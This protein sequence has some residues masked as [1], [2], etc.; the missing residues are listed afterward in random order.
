[1]FIIDAID[2]SEVLRDGFDRVPSQA[3]TMVHVEWVKSKIKIVPHFN[4]PD[5]MCGMRMWDASDA[6][7]DDHDDD[8]DL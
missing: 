6:T 7:W 4:N 1:M 2:R 3:T 8:Y 5:L